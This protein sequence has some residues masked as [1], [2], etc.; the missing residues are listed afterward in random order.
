[1]LLASVTPANPI[2]PHSGTLASIGTW[3]NNLGVAVTVYFQAA[4]PG[5]STA[6]AQTCC[7]KFVHLSAANVVKGARSSWWQKDA[8]A[9]AETHHYPV[10]AVKVANGEK[11][12]FYLS[13]DSAS[14]TSITPTVEIFDAHGA[15][16]V[17]VL[18]VA[19]SKVALADDA[20]TAAAFDESTAYP[21]KA[22]D[23]GAT[24]IAR[25]GN[26]MTLTEGAIAAVITA[27]LAI[28]LASASVAS[29]WFKRLADFVGAKVYADPATPQNVTDAQTAIITAMPDD[30]PIDYAKPGD[31]MTLTTAYNAAKTAVST[32]ELTAAQDAIQQDI[33][34]LPDLIP[35]PDM[36][37]A[38][39]A[40]KIDID[41]AAQRVLNNGAGVLFT[42]EPIVNSETGLPV[43]DVEVRLT[44]DEAGI[45]TEARDFT[46]GTGTITVRLPAGSYFVWLVKSGY[47][48]PDL[49]YS[50]EITA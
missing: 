27:I 26:A 11:V 4:F 8:A 49:P 41:A 36:E 33:A 18:Q 43:D 20:I 31:P 35:P 32:G 28:P 40:I 24:I 46:D 29:S 47:S 19:G 6:T 42:T 39:A 10:Q 13:S 9:N 44:S 16:I 22:A 12:Q 30:P 34:A 5:L 50:V 37:A 2:D 1:M 3:T 15:N 25:A 17:R 21:L 48:F 14:D 45:T 7:F 23:T 38:I